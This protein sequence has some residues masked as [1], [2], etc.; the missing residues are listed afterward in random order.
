M[1]RVETVEAI[2][3]TRVPEIDPESLDRL[4]A[5]HIYVHGLTFCV[6]GHPPALGLKSIGPD[7]T[8][9]D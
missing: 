4:T 9:I 3:L 7:R 5:G 8:K 1:R 2:G 6:C